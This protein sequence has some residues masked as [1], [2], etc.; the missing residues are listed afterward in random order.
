MG[1]EIRQENYSNL[2]N[3]QREGRNWC[4]TWLW[5]ALQ[6]QSI[7]MWNWKKFMQCGMAAAEWTIWLECVHHERFGSLWVCLLMCE[8][9]KMRWNVLL[10]IWIKH[11]IHIHMLHSYACYFTTSIY[12]F[13]TLNLDKY[14]TFIVVFNLDEE[15][16]KSNPFVD[17]IHKHM[18][19]DW[20][21]KTRVLFNKDYFPTKSKSN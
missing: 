7:I 19:I 8:S 10:F 9:V 2:A 5:C 11:N 14:F 1:D 6:M 3:V 18:L 12:T 13:L 20:Q 16:K 4:E 17:R 21:L 15:K